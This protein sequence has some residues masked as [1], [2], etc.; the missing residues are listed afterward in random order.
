[1][2]FIFASLLAIGL[3]SAGLAGHVRTVQATS[4]PDVPLSALPKAAQRATEALKLRR[5]TYSNDQ[6]VTR[7]AA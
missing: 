3:L 7:V 2:K 1:M 4:A 6:W 5:Q